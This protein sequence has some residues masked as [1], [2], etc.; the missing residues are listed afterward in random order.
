M[1]IT[2]MT[3]PAMVHTILHFT[4]QMLH[5]VLAIILLMEVQLLKTGMYVKPNGKFF[6]AELVG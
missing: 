4:K 2:T 3:M 5:M 6:S 1:A